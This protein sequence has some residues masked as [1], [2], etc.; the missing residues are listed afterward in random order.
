MDSATTACPGRLALARGPAL[1]TLGVT[2][3]RLVLELADAP[4]W[5]ASKKAGGGGALLGIFWLP[6]V[7]GP[8]FALQI[9]PAIPTFGRRVWR[10]VTTLAVY[11]YL[12]RIPVY[13]LF[14]VDEAFGWETHYA[15]F[16]DDAANYSFARKAGLLAL[17]QLGF[18]PLVW[19]VVT[20]GIAGVVT[21]ALARR[22]A[23]A[24][25]AG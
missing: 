21:F 24:V 20:G 10:L 12:A 13:I 11:G 8:W 16:P 1:I 7:F 23:A 2:L 19:T 14:F 4:P 6:F 5:L 15:A 25:P 22:R 3:L 17:S 18:W 9:A